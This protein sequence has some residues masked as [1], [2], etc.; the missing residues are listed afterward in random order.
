MRSLVY[1]QKLHGQQ[2]NDKNFLLITVILQSLC[3][4]TRDG[5]LESVR[6][7][8]NMICDLLKLPKP[9]PPVSSK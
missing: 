6:E 7:Q 3:L 8:R 9:K 2:K 1:S 4:Y 5:E